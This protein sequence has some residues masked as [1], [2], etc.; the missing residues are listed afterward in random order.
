MNPVRFGCAAANTEMQEV[1]P[2]SRKIGFR[3]Y[4]ISSRILGFTEDDFGI[5]EESRR[6]KQSG[7][8]TFRDTPEVEW[9]F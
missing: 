1:I 7:A 6:G 3:E 9:V 2:A 5:G 4:P 8:A